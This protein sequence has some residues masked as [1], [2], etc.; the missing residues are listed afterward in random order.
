MKKP[1]VIGIG[2][3]KAVEAQ[4]VEELKEAKPQ[5]PTQTT[6]NRWVQ[7][8]SSMELDS[9]EDM[10]IRQILTDLVVVDPENAR[11]LEI[12]PEQIRE[13]IDLLKINKQDTDFDDWKQ[14]YE[15]KAAKLFNGLTLVD[16]MDV[17]E[18]AFKLG[19]PE[20][21]INP[22]L[23]WR[24]ETRFHL[25]AGERRYLAHLLLGATHI[26][27][28]ILDPKPDDV[29]ISLFQY[30]ENHD[31]SDIRFKGTIVNH[32]R[33]IREWE[34]Q[35]D[36]KISVRKFAAL[37]S[38]GKS[39]AAQLLKIAK[40]Q[41]E[42][43]NHALNNNLITSIEQGYELSSMDDESLNNAVAMLV[44]PAAE[45]KG[46]SP[47]KKPAPKKPAKFPSSFKVTKKANKAALGYMVSAVLKGLD[48]KELEERI[49][50]YDMSKTAEL[51]EALEEI[52]HYIEDKFV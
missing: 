45:L 8:S 24:E 28:N 31:R 49:G 38:I 30:G 5:E 25:I 20:N 47:P 42:A 29:K 33:T 23:V 14:A 43:F 51:S 17:A 41:R 36:T 39:K 7:S 50:H 48:S 37:K 9:P 32:R 34:K 44:A 35:H 16:L 3:S 2:R 22:V 11:G 27:A 4:P 1:K 40:D 26:S 46:E 18:F 15:A 21:L 52:V 12:K 6:A 13:H 10:D 19:S